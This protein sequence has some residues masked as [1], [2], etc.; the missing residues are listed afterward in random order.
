MLAYDRPSR[1]SAASGVPDSPSGVRPDGPTERSA[2]GAVDGDRAG[3]ARPPEV[4]VVGGNVPCGVAALCARQRGHVAVFARDVVEAVRIVRLVPVV[5][6]V[7]CVVIPPSGESDA[8]RVAATLR[9]YA[10]ELPVAVVLGPSRLDDA[11]RIMWSFAA[12]V[13]NPVRDVIDDIAAQACIDW[14]TKTWEEAAPTLDV[15]ELVQRD[16]DRATSPADASR[17]D[18]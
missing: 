8:C 6:V 11:A 1:P 14:I 10:P 15:T 16:R 17:R 13:A 9:M 4:L 7:G 2:T 5:P 3:R 12:P 18:A